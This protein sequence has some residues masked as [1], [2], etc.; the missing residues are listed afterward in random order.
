M[1]VVADIDEFGVNRPGV[2]EAPQLQDPVGT[3]VCMSSHDRVADLERPVLH[4]LPVISARVHEL[5]HQ[6]FAEIVHP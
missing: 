2:R 4:V 6:E 3:R 1:G 5:D